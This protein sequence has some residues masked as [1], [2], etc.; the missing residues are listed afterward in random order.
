VLESRLSQ[1][2]D[3]SCPFQAQLFAFLMGD[4]LEDIISIFSHEVYL[5]T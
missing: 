4:I 3:L 1:S 5:R 2:S